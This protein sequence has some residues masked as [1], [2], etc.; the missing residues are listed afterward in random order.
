M[1]EKKG[2]FPEKDIFKWMHQ[3]ANGLRYLHSNNVI[4]RDIKPAYEFEYNNFFSFICL[5]IKKLTC[6]NNN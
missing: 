4:H 3:A 2:R 5:I 1:K 6:F